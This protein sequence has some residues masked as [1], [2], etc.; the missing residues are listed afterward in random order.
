MTEQELDL[1][2]RSVAKALDEADI[3]DIELGRQLLK[4]A[5]EVRLEFVRQMGLDD[6]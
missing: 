2:A 6:E 5:E 1:K 3:N 4:Q